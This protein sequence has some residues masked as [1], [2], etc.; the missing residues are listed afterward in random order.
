[1]FNFLKETPKTDKELQD[2]MR[3]FVNTVLVK[4]YMTFTDEERYE[5]LLREFYH[6]NLV[7]EMQL[8]RQEKKIPP[9]VT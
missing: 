3:A 9:S 4:N 2:D 1:M 6:R 7:P 5:K 8:K